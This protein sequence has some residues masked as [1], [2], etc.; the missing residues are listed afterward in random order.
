[1]DIVFLNMKTIVSNTKVNF[2]S[3]SVTQYNL[4]EEGKKLKR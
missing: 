3:E 1:M 4:S 2:S